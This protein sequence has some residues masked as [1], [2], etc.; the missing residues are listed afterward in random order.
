MPARSGTALACLLTSLCILFLATGGAGRTGDSPDLSEAPPSLHQTGL[1]AAADSHV[2]DPAHLGFA[3][4]YPLWTDGASKRRWISL[5]PGEMIDASDPDAWDFPIGTRFWKEFAFDGRAIETRFMLRRPDGSWFFATYIW[6]EAGTAA[7][8]VPANGI[9]RGFEFGDGTAH[10]IPSRADCAACHMSGRSPVLGFSMLQLSDDRDPNALHAEPAP[11]P[12][13][14]LRAIEDRGLILG[15][16]STFL[17]APPR[18]ST[19]SAAQRSALGYLHGNCGH[20]HNPYGPLN[21][22]GLFLRQPADTARSAALSTT[23]R[24]VL[25]KP[26]AGIL[27]GTEFRIAPGDPQHSAIPQRMGARAS[28]LQMPPLGTARID[29]EAVELI[30]RWIT[31]SR[32]PLVSTQPQVSN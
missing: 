20:C 11:P 7:T 13:L 9:L 1:Y 23:F 4:Q 30:N 24:K 3:P 28:A 6:D 17:L 29:V 2:V 32:I 5:P 27:P 22:L 10:A 26:P 12:G 14:T 21:R 18:T 25:M 16:G 8:L 19:A 31:E 15:L